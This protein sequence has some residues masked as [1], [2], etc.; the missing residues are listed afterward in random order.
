MFCT[1]SHFGGGGDRVVCRRRLGRAPGSFLLML[2]AVVAGGWCQVAVWAGAN[3]A[4]EGRERTADKCNGRAGKP[5]E[6]SMS[7]TCHYRRDLN[8][9]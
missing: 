3:A 4:Y 9:K 2:V 5:W 1:A 6:K 8:L 7:L